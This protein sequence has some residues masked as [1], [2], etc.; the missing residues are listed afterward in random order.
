MEVIL[1]DFVMNLGL[2]MEYDGQGNMHWCGLN[3]IYRVW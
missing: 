3:S 1:K 2:P